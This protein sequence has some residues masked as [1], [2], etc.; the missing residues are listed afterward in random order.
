MVH[1]CIM[2]CTLYSHSPVHAHIDINAARRTLTLLLLR[3]GVEQGLSTVESRRN[4][5]ALEPDYADEE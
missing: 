1:A 3:T 5:D 4:G 2:H